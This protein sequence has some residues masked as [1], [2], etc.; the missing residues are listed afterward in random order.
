LQAVRQAGSALRANHQQPVVGKRRGGGAVEQLLA[1]QITDPVC[2]RTDKNIC[3]SSG[4]DLAGQ[5]SRAREI[6]NGFRPGMGLDIVIGQ[7]AYYF[8]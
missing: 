4:F 1:L 7:L 8:S 2:I 3:W 5:H 6:G